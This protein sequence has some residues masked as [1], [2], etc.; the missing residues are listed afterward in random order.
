MTAWP[1]VLLWF[2][3]ELAPIWWEPV[4][5]A[6]YTVHMDSKEHIEHAIRTMLDRQPHEGEI[7]Q[8]LTNTYTRTVRC[9]EEKVR[10]FVYQDLEGTW[11]HTQSWWAE[12]MI[13]SNRFLLENLIRILVS[14][15]AELCWGQSGCR[16]IWVGLNDEII[17][18]WWR[19]LTPPGATVELSPSFPVSPSPSSQ[20]RFRF[21]NGLLRREKARVSLLTGP[22]IIPT[23][24]DATHYVA[25]DY[26]WNPFRSATNKALMSDVEIL[27][28][29]ARAV[30]LRLTSEH[31]PQG[32]K[33]STWR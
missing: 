10:V 25:L 7:D 27:L 4:L 9:G 2:P 5:R 30:Q 26:G 17:Q 31:S 21:Q 29:N 14:S 23:S 8:R 1:P 20:E 33:R 11:D 32:F 13:Y 15:G 28:V 3:A 6:G 18:S 22:A 19:T 12:I 24:R 16:T